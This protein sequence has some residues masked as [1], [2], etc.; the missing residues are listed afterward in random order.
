[1]TEVTITVPDC[2]EKKCFLF[3]VRLFLRTVFHIVAVILFWFVLNYG[4]YV[5]YLLMTDQ[6]QFDDPDVALIKWFT[7][8]FLTNWNFV[9]LFLRYFYNMNWDYI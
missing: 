9:S 3:Y 2:E 1:M 5:W 7:P 6:L 8:L 4:I